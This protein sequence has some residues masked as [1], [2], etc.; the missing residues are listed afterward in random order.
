M[1]PRAERQAPAGAR[2]LKLLGTEIEL[3][4]SSGGE[5]ICDHPTFLLPQRFPL[6]DFRP[7]AKGDARWPETA[8]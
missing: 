1:N 4:V 5:V 8:I 2:L 3:A 7:Q 6:S